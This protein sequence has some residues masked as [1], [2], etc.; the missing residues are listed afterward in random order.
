MPLLRRMTHLEK[1]ALSLRVGER[2]SFIDG[3][4]LDS[5][6]LSQ[7]P[8]LHT[9]HFYIVISNMNFIIQVNVMFFRFH[10]L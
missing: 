1:L 7:M 3:T 6:I 4:Y 9:F 8:H 5:Y 10:V 2:D